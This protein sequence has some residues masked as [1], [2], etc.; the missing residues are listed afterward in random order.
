MKGDLDMYPLKYGEQTV[1][2][3]GRLFDWEAI[4]FYMDN[5][6]RKYLHRKLA[7]CTNEEFLQA[8]LDECP[9]FVTAY[10]GC[11]YP[12]N[13]VLAEDQTAFD[14]LASKYELEYCGEQYGDLNWYSDK[15][16]QLEVYTK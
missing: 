2:Y 1:W 12:L 8:Y 10:D 11:L 4:V 9:A 13:R 14:E 7:P 3:K 15:G 5:D 6:M 16:N